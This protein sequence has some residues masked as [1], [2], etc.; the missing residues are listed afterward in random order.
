[1]SHI[2][3]NGASISADFVKGF[4]EFEAFVQSLEGHI[5]DWKGNERIK[6]LR[7]IWNQVNPPDKK[8]KEAESAAEPAEK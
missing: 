3:F 2:T 7:S 6:N 8:K 4:K 5:P 1:M